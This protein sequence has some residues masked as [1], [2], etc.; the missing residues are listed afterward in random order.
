MKSKKLVLA[1][2]MATLLVLPVVSTFAQG[3]GDLDTTV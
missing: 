1:L 3:I 2:V